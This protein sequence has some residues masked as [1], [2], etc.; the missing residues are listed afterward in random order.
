MKK[1]LSSI[2]VIMFVY[3][4]SSANVLET[5]DPLFLHTTEKPL[6]YCASLSFENLNNSKDLCEVD[7]NRNTTFVVFDDYTYHECNSYRIISYLSHNLE[8]LHKDIENEDIIRLNKAL[9]KIN[10]MICNEFSV[11]ELV[12][13]KTS[14]TSNISYHDHW[15]M[16]IKNLQKVKMEKNFFPID[17]NDFEGFGIRLKI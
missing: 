5:L 4:S 10:E 13:S 3:G 2:I 11:R 15:D 1:I 12:Q 9:D 17:A 14:D 8:Y 7:L 6:R 16:N